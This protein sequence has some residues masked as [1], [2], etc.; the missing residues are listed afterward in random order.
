MP[1]RRVT[2]EAD[3][4]PLDDLDTIRRRAGHSDPHLGV[5]VDDQVVPEREDAIRR[6]VWVEEREVGRVNAAGRRREREEPVGGD[7][8]LRLDPAVVRK[9]E[10]QLDQSDRIVTSEGQHRVRSKRAERG[11]VQTWPNVSCWNPRT[12]SLVSAPSTVT[13][14][15]TSSKQFC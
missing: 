3:V 10:A 4:V 7:E 1:Q 14:T 11:S 2:E 15:D 12:T 9:R 5:L 8:G 6:R 13:G